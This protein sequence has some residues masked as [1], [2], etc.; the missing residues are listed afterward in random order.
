[1]IADFRAKEPAPFDDH[2]IE[3]VVAGGLMYYGT[4]RTDS[5][6]R[7]AWLVAQDLETRREILVEQPKVCSW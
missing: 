1:M 5:Y 2:N 7:V 6:P 3:S 4:E